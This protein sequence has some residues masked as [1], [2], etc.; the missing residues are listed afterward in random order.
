LNNKVYGLNSDKIKNLA[1]K[2]VSDKT[3]VAQHWQ[4]F[5]ASL[6]IEDILQ[7]E[8]KVIKLQ[9]QK[10]VEHKTF[11]DFELENLSALNNEEQEFINK[12]IEDFKLSDNQKIESLKHLKK[13][14][15]FEEFLSKKFIG[16][17]RF[18]IEGLESTI[19][20][21]EQIKQ[22]SLASNI[23]HLNLAMAHRGRLN[24]LANF[25]GKPYKKI[26]AGFLGFDEFE[27]NI[28]G[29]VKYHLGL[30]TEFKQDSNILKAKLFNNPSHLEAANS[31]AMG[32]TYALQQ[33]LCKNDVLP[34]IMHGDSAFAGQGS[35]AETLNMAYIDGYNIGG[36]VH[37]IQNNKIGFTAEPLETTSLYCTNI[38]KSLDAP[39]IHVNAENILEVIKAASLAFAYRQQFNKDIFI[40]LI[41]YRKYGHNEGDDPTFTNPQVYSALKQKNSMYKNYKDELIE[42]NIT[43][44]AQTKILED[45]FLDLLNAEYTEAEKLA[46]QTS[47]YSTDF[48]L[49]NIETNDIEQNIDENFVAKFADTLQTPIA[50]FSLN[51]KLEKL[52]YNRRQSLINST[53]DGLDWGTTENL[54]YASLVNDG[55]SVRL[56]GQDSKRGTFSHRHLALID[57]ENGNSLIL[58]NS[59]AKKGA[60][61]ST[62]NSP[63]SEYAIVG[64]EYGYSIAQTSPSLTIWEA[65]FGDFANGAQI[66]FDQ[67]LFSGFQKWNE[68][69]NLVLMLPH[70][71][72]GQGPEHSSARIERFL[73]LAGQNNMLIANPSSVE[74]EFHLLRNQAHANKPLVLFTPK[75]LL[76]RK[77]AN[78]KISDL[79]NGA[80]KVIKNENTSKKARQVVFCSGKIYHDLMVRKNEEKDTSTVIIAIE[81]LYPMPIKQIK[82]V[83][84]QYKGA[85]IKWVQEEPRNCGCFLYMQDQFLTNFNLKLDYIGIS[86]KASPAVGNMQLHKKQQEYILQQVF[87]K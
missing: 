34:V 18:S 58:S 56:S 75:S 12:T 14:I 80:F 83:L 78:A 52:L 39:I 25:M 81:Q 46:K 61:I 65:Q 31:V 26:I 32:H 45:D 15:L 11:A 70:G 84:E 6:E 60:K 17:K 69:N 43:T 13:A 10:V 64:F 77:E 82:K 74:Q 68:K 16:V 76:R 33:Q 20:L 35:V 38:A 37:I 63:V 44:L 3:S 8:K 40:D 5:F 24:V 71:Y 7:T 87:K 54:A 48:A 36:T 1:K 29:D 59:L 19:I 41:G 72:E 53:D 4:D 51:K 85:D 47:N 67:F 50:N 22:L 27:G 2:Y 42:Q 79:T 9:T 62:Y 23:K 49:E 73:S 28:E 66:M 57:Q 30:E 21:L 55:I 86:A